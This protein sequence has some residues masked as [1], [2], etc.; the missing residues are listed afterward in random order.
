VSKL[1]D[2]RY[3]V[4]ATAR[5][6]GK[7]K[8]KRKVLRAGTS[9]SAARAKVEKMRQKLARAEVV[10]CGPTLE[11]YCKRWLD[12]AKKRIRPGSLLARSSDLEIVTSRIG[13]ILVKDLRREHLE[14]LARALEHEKGAKGKP[15]S[16]ATLASVWVRLRSLLEDAVEDG[17]I[18]SNPMRR[19]QAPR[20]HAPSVRERRTLSE[21]ELS[22]FLERVRWLDE[23]GERWTAILVLATTGMRN[24]ELMA[25]QWEDIGEG[26]IEVRR[27]LWRGNEGPTKT[28]DPRSVPIT[29]ALRE[30]L[31]LHRR[32]MLATQAPGLADGRVFPDLAERPKW[33]MHV[34]SE[35]IGLDFHV[36]PQVLRRTFN[37]LLLLA[38][39]D[40]VVIRAMMGHC[41]E[42]MTEH[43]AGVSDAV[44]QAAAERLVAP[45]GSSHAG[46]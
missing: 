14:F 30:A 6:E 32:R 39:V 12:E 37:T 13:G 33:L 27:S 29:A 23:D 40:R 35:R 43:Y 17:L 20:S 24:G 10:D 42:Q 28:G 31:Q 2:G 38:G 3:R 45:A 34:A 15:Y 9:L 1:P 8:W 4:E 11:G 46:K 22:K 36:T 5:V 19:V 7:R 16:R 26:T 25:L 18:G 44:K 41:S 21:A